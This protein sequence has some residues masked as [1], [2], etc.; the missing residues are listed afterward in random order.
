M[1][2]LLQ[3]PKQTRTELNTQGMDKQNMTNICHEILRSS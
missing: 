1:I 3:Q 2:F